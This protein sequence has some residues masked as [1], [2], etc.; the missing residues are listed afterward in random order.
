MYRQMVYDTKVY[1]NMYNEIVLDYLDREKNAT[2]SEKIARTDMAQNV[3][4]L[5]EHELHYFLMSFITIIGSLYFVFFHHILTGF[6]VLSSIPFVLLIIK[7]Y[8]RK[9]EQGTRVGN[10]HYEQKIDI[11]E[12]F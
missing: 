8:Y 6:I 11:M 5:L 9:I 1:M 4:G 10:T 7:F 12:M 2:T 3:V